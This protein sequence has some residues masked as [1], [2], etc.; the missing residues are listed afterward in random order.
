[1]LTTNYSRSKT[2]FTLI[3]LLFA[4]FIASAWAI[5]LNKS[6]LLGLVFVVGI[7]YVCALFF[8]PFW[9]TLAFVI[10]SVFGPLLNIPIT[11]DGL[12]L[13]LAILFTAFLVWVTKAVLLKDRDL[14]LL[15][16][17]SPAHV[18]LVAFLMVMTISLVNT[19]D[20]AVS[21]AQIKRFTYCIIIYFYM[22]YSVKDESQL[23]KVFA[24][25]LTVYFLVSVLGI[26]EA[27]SGTRVYE[28]LGGKSLF[29]ASVPGAVLKIS[30]K[31]R[32]QGVMGNAEFHSFRMISFFLF[33]CGA[34][35]LAKSKFQK[36]V[37][38]ILMLLAIMNVIGTAYRGAII[39]LGVSFFAF[40]L[41]SKI[42][43]KWLIFALSLSSITLVGL[44]LYV[45]FPDLN[46]ERLVKIEGKAVETVD[47]RKNNV[48]IG[49]NMTLDH[50][51]IGNGPDGFVLQY[52]RYTRDFPGARTEELKTHNTYIQ[53]LAEYGIVGLTIFLLFL[54]IAARNAYQ[55]LKKA[56]PSFGFLILSLLATLAAH[57]TLMGGANVLLDHNFWLI[58][59]VAGIA[60]RI[61]RNSN[62][63][64]PCAKVAMS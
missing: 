52:N 28:F 37:V 63:E 21:L 53:V 22:I 29:G 14:F 41:L 47:M 51:I 36:I 8:K 45:A 59:A 23:K 17:Q 50:P 4:L 42:R 3:I 33:S 11:G 24:V 44:F 64:K 61:S 32:I 43:Q 2:L 9:A 57:F 26:V 12:L 60:E 1:M 34:F 58:L 18:F 15:P 48:I 40:L 16:I 62:T 25:M 31:G 10:T 54:F 35:F 20:M 38:G 13:S 39:A 49:F 5:L 19:T 56:N 30:E 7:A 27:I 55:S 46:I 6:V